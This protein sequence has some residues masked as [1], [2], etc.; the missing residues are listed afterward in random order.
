MEDKNISFL[1]TR[2]TPDIGQRKLT[3]KESTSTMFQRESHD[4]AQSWK[5][6]T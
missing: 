6:I 1:E 4:R 3:G 2:Y 5:C